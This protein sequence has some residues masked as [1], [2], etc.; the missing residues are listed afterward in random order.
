MKQL[1]PP[2]ETVPCAN[3]R[4]GRPLRSAASKARGMGPVCWDQ[5]HPRPARHHIPAGPTASTGRAPLPSGPD[6]F[7]DQLPVVGP[8]GAP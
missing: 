5:A 6:L 1:A 4:C 2:V 8:D 7:D 3:Q